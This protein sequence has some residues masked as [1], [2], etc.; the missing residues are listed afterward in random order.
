[1]S[2]PANNAAVIALKAS[3]HEQF[4]AGMCEKEHPQAVA[5]QER[6]TGSGSGIDLGDLPDWSEE[7]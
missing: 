4:W 2:L 7:I 3:R 5:E 1:L 6:S